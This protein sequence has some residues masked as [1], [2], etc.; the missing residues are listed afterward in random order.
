MFIAVFYAAS[1]NARDPCSRVFP[2]NVATE[3]IFFL[4]ILF[5]SFS[6]DEFRREINKPTRPDDSLRSIQCLFS[7]NGRLSAGS[8]PGHLP[9]FL[10]SSILFLINFPPS[11]ISSPCAAL[12]SYDGQASVFSFFFFSSRYIT[13]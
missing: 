3:S 12:I 9:S 10:A 11:L 2:F 1:S 13:P 7:F 8:V 5:L 4:G 6:A